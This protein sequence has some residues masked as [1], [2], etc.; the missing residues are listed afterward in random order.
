MTE[1]R[2][3]LAVAGLV[4]DHVWGELAHWQETGRVDFVA[5]ADPNADL[6]DRVVREFGVEAVFDSTEEMFAQSD[7]DVVQVC[8]S[9]ADGVA[10]VEAAARLGIHA[11]VEKPLA[12]TL[13]G[14]NRMLQAA[15]SAGTQL[16]VN[17]PFR[18]RPATVQ[19]WRLVSDGLI[20]HVFNAQI[21]MAHKGP[22]EFGC[23][24]HFCNWLYDASQNGAGALIDY[25]CYGAVALRHLFGM[26]QHVQG[27][28][29]CLTKTDIPVDDNAAITLLYPDRFA[30]TEASWSQIPS[31]HDALFL[32]T[33]ATL[34]TR[35]GRLFVADEE[36][37][38]Q[39]I[40]VEDLPRGERSGPEYFLK[41]LDED[42]EP[43]DVC[44]AV[45][46]R[47]AQEILE[48]GLRSHETGRR[49]GLPL[50]D[51]R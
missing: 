9:N 34:W 4:H 28:A 31:Y 12:A 47:D 48:A 44:S 21:R 10:V 42:R 20:G 7:V 46:C 27:V 40:P 22:R 19:A 25:C 50:D 33:R 39:E 36:H 24:D 13:D 16:M 35:N 3:R 14:A 38:E 5:A 1:K 29:G 30:T 2:Y 15:E 17:W 8:T 26:P 45:V 6:R 51:E 11:V 32:G 49:M 37:G 23:S 43:G 18:W 41:C